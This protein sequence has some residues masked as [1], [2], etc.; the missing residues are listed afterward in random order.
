MTEAVADRLAGRRSHLAATPLPWLAAL[1]AAYLAIP[2][3]AFLGRLASTPGRQ[4]SS[5]GVGAALVVSLETATIATVVIALTGVP[6]AYLLARGK[7]RTSTV[8][9]VLVQLPIALPPLMSGILLLY[10]VGPYSMLGRLFGGNLTDDFTGIVLAQI[11]VAAPFGIVAARSAF[12]ALDPAL[13]DVAAT[14][15]HRRF[16]RFTRVA[17]P[18]AAPGIAAGLLLS[19]LRAFG[20]FGATVVLAYHPYSLPVFTYVQFG[21]TGLPATL[22]PVAASLGAAAVVLGLALAVPR[23]RSRPA[24][25]APLPPARPPVP[26]PVAPLDFELAGR[27]GGFSL[28]IEHRGNTGRLGILGASG[29]GK[30]LTLRLLAGLAALDRGEIRLGG[31]VLTAAPPETRGVGYLPQETSLLPHL[32]VWSQVNFG[33]GADSALAAYW[34]E[35]LHLDPL[36]DRR[37]DQLSGGQRRRVGLARALARDPRLLLL[38][39]PLAGLDTPRR[40]ELR[41]AMRRL[42][43]DTGITTVVVTHDVEDAALLADELLILDEGR[44]LQAGRLADLVARPASLQVARL[45][46]LDNINSAAVVADGALLTGGT[47]VAARTAGLAPGTK[48]GWAIPPEAVE[49][50]PLG[51]YQSTVND[52][53]RKSDHLQVEL[54][55]GRGDL[56]LTSRMPADRRVR[57]GDPQA[58]ALPTDAITIWVDEGNPEPV[59]S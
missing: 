13:E 22:L 43:L 25:P 7:R 11:F 5:P 8:L 2:L 49:F 10:L 38:D 37:P 53:V 45:L 52:V 24:V 1:L 29:A 14:L 31:A 42:Q 33:V 15:G 26:Q 41:R 28:A 50:T 59:E 56:V 9:G 32:P 21:S 20:E 3:V 34:V 16:A 44:L 39:E 58:V 12:A 27:M 6:L 4:M 30:T 40:A 17:L 51:D 55:I 18:A 35:R 36:V 57:V 23:V 46:G 54:A 47:L 48:V 19:W